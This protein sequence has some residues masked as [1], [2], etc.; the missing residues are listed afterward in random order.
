MKRADDGLYICVI[1]SVTNIDVLEQLMLSQ[2]FHVS[3][4]LLLD[5]WS[6]KRG[7]R[8]TQGGSKL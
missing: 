2:S 6:E 4:Y 8:R 3:V 5:C 7:N 1:M